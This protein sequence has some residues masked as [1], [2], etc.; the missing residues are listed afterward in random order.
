MVI[1]IVCCFIALIASALTFFSGFGLGTL[2]TPIFAIYFPIELSIIMT[3]IVH[4]LNNL[5]KFFLTKKN[6]NKVVLY[7]FGVTALLGSLIGA[8]VLKILINFNIKFA[9]EFLSFNFLTTPTKLAIGVLIIF[10]TIFESINDIKIKNNQ[11]N[12]LLGGL[13]S[14]F[15][16]GISGNQ[17]ALRT[18]FLANIG[19]TKES[20]IATGIAISLIIDCTRLGIYYANFSQVDYQINFNLIFVVTLFA[21]IGAYFG[22]ILL[23]K[24]TINI[25]NK[26]IT[27]MLLTIGLMLCFGII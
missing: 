9:F 13:F 7:S 3:A 24:I 6:I 2:L 8:F 20:L 25:I 15:F 12:L 5:F 22:S 4:F 10:F 27:L 17:G 19:L 1:Y 26:I 16:G 11:S 23:T 18:L 21:F 14:G